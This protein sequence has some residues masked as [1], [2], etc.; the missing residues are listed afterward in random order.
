MVMESQTLF[1]AENR[2]AP[3]GIISLAGAQELSKKVEAHLVRWAKLAGLDY[4]TFLLE[5][6]CPRVSSGDGKGMINSTV[7][8]YDLFFIVDVGNYSLTYNYFGQENRMS[9]DDHYQ[10][11]KRLIQAASGKAHRMNVVMPLLYGGRQHRRSYRESLDCAYML[12]ELQHMGVSNLLTFDAHD[13]RVQNAVPV[14]GFDNLMPEYQVLKKLF[15]D[16][17]DLSTDKNDFMIVSPDEGALNRNM[18]YASVLGVEL[19]MFYKRRDYSRIV[20]GRN[21]IVAHEYLGASVEGKDV[22][23][24]DDIISSGESVL[25][26]AENVKDRRAN[27]FFAYATYAIFTNGL[28]KFDKAYEQGL[29]DGIFGSNLTY[30][31]PELRN[32]PWFHEVDVSKYIAYF[33]SAL[34]HDVSIS[35]LLDPHSKIEA[36]LKKRALERAKYADEQL[37]L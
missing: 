14:M 32:R 20:D 34:N 24:A 29:I 9:P 26:I 2:V 7:R 22:F 28:E 18:H 8:G 13:P 27:R 23:V 19:G 15:K 30:L 5:S 37:S 11:L 10:D 31:K 35:S 1:S 3:L 6:S 25:D 21:P 4:D 17:P 36:L 33:I 16:F 12:Q